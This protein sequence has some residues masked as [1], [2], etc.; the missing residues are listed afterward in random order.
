MWRSNFCIIVYTL[1]NTV[2]SYLA[3][4]SQCLP[5]HPGG[6]N[7]PHVD[8]Q[9]SHH[10]SGCL[11]Q[12]LFP[13][14][15]GHFSTCDVCQDFGFLPS[16]NVWSSPSSCC[17]K[18]NAILNIKGTDLSR[19]IWK[20]LLNA[21][22]TYLSNQL[23]VTYYT[24]EIRKKLNGFQRQNIKWKHKYIILYQFQIAHFLPIIQFL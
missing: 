6:L 15:H 17:N 9:A 10:P 19:K 13:V 20:R 16:A 11:T 7:L 14:Q 8:F 24:E 23:L 5:K 2:F 4:Q 22:E 1:K 3:D 21:K 12:Q 18:K